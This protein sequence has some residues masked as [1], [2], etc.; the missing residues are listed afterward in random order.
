[1]KGEQGK[2]V[3]EEGRKLLR[4]DGE[5]RAGKELSLPAQVVEAGPIHFC[6]KER[7]T[8]REKKP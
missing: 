3:I 5:K 7:E 8:P 1:M 6:Q 4:G 2:R